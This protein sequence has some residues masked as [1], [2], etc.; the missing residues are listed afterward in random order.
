MNLHRERRF[1]EAENLY[2]QLHA[3][4]PASV[5]VIHLIGLVAYDTG[6]FPEALTWMERAIAAQ[7]QVARYHSNLGLLLADW[8]RLEESA[9]ALETARQLEPGSPDILYNLG[10]T[11]QRLRQWDAAIA[12]YQRA[13]ELRPDHP[14]TWLNLGLSLAAALRREEA[15]ARYEDA[16]K[17]WPADATLAC[18]HGTVLHEMGRLDE[19][20]VAFQAALDLEPSNAV[21]LNNLGVLYKDR[22]DIPEALSALRKCLSVQPSPAVQSN[23]IY[24]SLMDPAAKPEQIAQE[25]QRW[26]LQYAAPLRAQRP[27]HTNNR[28]PSRRLRIGYVSCDLRD[29][30]VGRTFLPIFEAHDLAQVECVCYGGSTTDSVASRFRARAA[31]WR[32]MDNWSD[33]QL[34]AQIHADGVDVLVDLGLHT[35]YNRL[36]SFAL[37]PAPVQVSWLGYPG[38]SEVETIDYWL[39]DRFLSPSEQTTDNPIGQ[40][41]RLPNAWCCY[42]APEDSPDVTGLPV[43]RNGHIRFGSFNN[44]SKINERVLALWARILQAVPD[45]QLVLLAKIGMHWDRAKSTLQQHGVAVD[46]IE[47]LAYQPWNPQSRPSDYLRRY[48]EVD[49]AL[50]PFPYN[51]MTTTGDA[52]WMGVPVVTLIGNNATGRAS[53]SL[54]SNVALPELAATTEDGYVQIAAALANDRSRLASLRSTLR[55]RMKSSPLLDVAGFTRALE[56]AYRDMWRR[57][58]SRPSP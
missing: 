44:F 48:D 55:D 24:L 53:F 23:V 43:L 25:E 38:S 11:R 51:G 27:I 2:R 26:N 21:A 42:P 31:Q 19:A 41:Y 56:A 50:D 9:R 58:C 5:D 54:L 33:A 28:S 40:P 7:P 22:G 30:V 45:S 29:H 15:V 20:I 6:R 57:W 16:R 1:A 46:R 14:K 17:R 10:L 47:F 18:N 32:E 35:A 13:L 12:C 39:S 34:A 8:N 49:I 52:L 4:F 37:R 36:P 3:Q